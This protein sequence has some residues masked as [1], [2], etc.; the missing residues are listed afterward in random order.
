MIVTNCHVAAAPEVGGFVA[1]IPQNPAVVVQLG[2]APLTTVGRV[3]VGA[4]VVLLTFVGEGKLALH[5]LIFAVC[6]I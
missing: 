1:G 2:G 4:A 6:T 5:L 3:D